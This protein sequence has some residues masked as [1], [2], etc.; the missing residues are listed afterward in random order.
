MDKEDEPDEQ[1]QLSQ[2]APLLPEGLAFVPYN[3]K[4]PVDADERQEIDAA[5]HVGA[6]QEHFKL[7]EKLPKWPPVAKAEIGNPERSN[8]DDQDISQ[9][10]AELQD[11]AR[12]PLLDAAAEHPEAGAVQQDTGQQEKGPQGGDGGGQPLGHAVHAGVHEGEEAS[13]SR[14]VGKASALTCEGWGGRENTVKPLEL[15]IVRL[16]WIRG[17][18]DRT[19]RG[20][21]LNDS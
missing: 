8:R 10:Q 13:G 3:D 9:D 18:S 14:D 11:H 12:I 7:A 5:V 6:V 4:V 1:A 21:F 17:N 16:S 19:S 15:I 2:E 20:R